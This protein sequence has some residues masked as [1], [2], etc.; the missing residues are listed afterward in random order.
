MSA[1]E[2]KPKPCDRWNGNPPKECIR[3]CAI[4]GPVFYSCMS[5]GWEE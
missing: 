5:C 1:K 3:K 4:G 2:E